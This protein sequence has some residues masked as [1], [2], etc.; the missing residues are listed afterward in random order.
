MSLKKQLKIKL[1]PKSR[2][3]GKKILM[4]KYSEHLILSEILTHSQG[5]GSH[6]VQLRDLV[7]A[8]VTL[9]LIMKKIFYKKD[10]LIQVVMLGP[11][12]KAWAGVV[13]KTVQSSVKLVF[14]RQK[15]RKIPVEYHHY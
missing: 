2:E 11:S 1:N 3:K 13:S 4:T 5:Q 12:I 7:Q 10:H 6:P 14:K 8:E 15:S 9:K